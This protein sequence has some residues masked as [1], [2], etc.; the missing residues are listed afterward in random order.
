MT[1]S[2]VPAAVGRLAFGPWWLLYSGPIEATE[3][4]SHST[5]Q[6]VV[7]AGGPCVVDEA[8]HP[9]TGPIVVIEPHQ[10][11]AFADHRDHALV[12]YVD[13]DSSAA[14]GLDDRRS[15]RPSGSGL[16][17]VAGMVGALRPENWSRAEETVRRVLEAVCE[18]PA[19]ERP[20]WWRHPAIDGAIL[21]LP[22]D[23]EEPLS[24]A[25]LAT[26]AGFTADRL[27]TLLRDELGVRL[28]S[29]T[30]W[31]RLVQATENLASGLSLEGA[32]SS[33][34]YGSVWE[35]VEQFQRMFGLTPTG[36]V[37]LGQL[38]TS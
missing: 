27:E 12:V 20:M 37:A 29:Y 2:P 14:A 30:R 9:L 7:H 13:A 19:P 8:H 22:T 28:P 15:I 38:L 21:R 35:L 33:A 11:H 32:A 26:D 24:L 31:M 16:H 23:P 18:R 25:E 10:P 3:S 17:P 4:H 34:G 5:F 6:I 36:M 1:R